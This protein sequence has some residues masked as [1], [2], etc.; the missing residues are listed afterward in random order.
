MQQT[1]TNTTLKVWSVDDH[2][3][4]GCAL[5]AIFQQ[6]GDNTEFSSFVSPAAVR[7]ELNHQRAD[8]IVIDLL[9]PNESGVDLI[10]HIAATHPEIVT[11]VYTARDD[12]AYIQSCFKAGASGY[13]TKGD[14]VPQFLRAVRAVLSGEKFLSESLRVSYGE[15]E[16][17]REPDVANNWAVL[18]RRERDVMMLIGKGQKTHEIAKTLCRSVKTV[19]TYKARIKQKLGLDNATQLAQAAWILSHELSSKAR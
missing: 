9:Y 12:P 1:E 11:L 10:A 18:S 7:T 2:P 8:L 13:V 14:S 5:E 6:Y 17:G 3:I 16:A 15:A 19:E 4:T